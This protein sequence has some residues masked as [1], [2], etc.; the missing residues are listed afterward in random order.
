MYKCYITARGNTFYIKFIINKNI[1]V[2]TSN[3]HDAFLSKV[4]I[5]IQCETL[6]PKHKSRVLC[7]GIH[8]YKT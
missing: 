8:I 7:T 5:N 4:I 2:I 1:I 3:V 6:F